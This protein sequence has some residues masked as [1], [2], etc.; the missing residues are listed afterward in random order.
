M[1]D[2]KLNLTVKKFFNS[3]KIQQA[4]ALGFQ[5]RMQH[6]FHPKNYRLNTSCLNQIKTMQNVSGR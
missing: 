4:G 5:Y 3:I 2:Q 6:L 1:S